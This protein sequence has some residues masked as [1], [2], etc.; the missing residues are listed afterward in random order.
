MTEPSS[1]ENPFSPVIRRV[2]S[3]TSRPGALAGCASSPEGP[4]RF[5]GG[6]SGRVDLPL[7]ATAYPMNKFDR[8]S[9]LENVSTPAAVRTSHATDRRARVTVHD[10]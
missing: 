10:R 5:R 9:S 8:T 2:A 1:I 3:K 6:L 7:S 4:R